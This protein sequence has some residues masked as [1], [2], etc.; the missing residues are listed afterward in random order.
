MCGVGYYKNKKKIL[1]EAADRSEL[2][3]NNP[4]QT[5]VCYQLITVR[6]AEQICHVQTVSSLRL[7]KVLQVVDLYWLVGTS[8][9]LETVHYQLGMQL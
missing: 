4:G 1:A 6:M 9:G 8:Y 7:G 2:Y 3:M 5:I